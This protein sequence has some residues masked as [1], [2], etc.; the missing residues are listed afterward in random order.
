MTDT[1]ALAASGTSELQPD[2]LDKTRDDSHQ[3]F[4][5]LTFRTNQRA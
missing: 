3:S 5:I 1:T 4:L 2:D